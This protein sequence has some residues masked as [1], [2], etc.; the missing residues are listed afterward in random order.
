MEDLSNCI[1]YDITPCNNDD[2]E[3]KS[4]YFWDLFTFPLIFDVLLIFMNIQI[5]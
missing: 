3:L 5:R 1:T 2:L 4:F